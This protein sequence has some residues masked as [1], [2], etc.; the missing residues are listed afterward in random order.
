MTQILEI[1]NTN[2]FLTGMFMTGSLWGTFLLTKIFLPLPQGLTRHSRRALLMKGY[3]H[4][5]F[6]EF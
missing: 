6:H 4:K 3:R 5:S 1:L 2:N